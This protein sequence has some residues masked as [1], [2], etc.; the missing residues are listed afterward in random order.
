MERTSSTSRWV[1][2]G[3]NNFTIVQLAR[4][5]P[6]RSCLLHRTYARQAGT[7]QTRQAGTRQA[8]QGTGTSRWVPGCLVG[9][10]GFAGACAGLGLGLGRVACHP[11]QCCT[12]RN[13]RLIRWAYQYAYNTRIWI[14]AKPMRNQ[15][16]FCS[17]Q[18]SAVLLSFEGWLCTPRHGGPR[19]ANWHG[20]GHVYDIPSGYS[21]VSQ[22]FFFLSRLPERAEQRSAAPLEPLRPMPLRKGLPFKERKEAKSRVPSNVLATYWPMRRQYAYYTRIGICR[23]TYCATL[24]L[25]LPSYVPAGGSEH[26][27]LELVCRLRYQLK[28]G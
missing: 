1:L 12:I 19:E 15:Y 24:I 20:P 14:L 26:A 13:A 11:T 28:F 7:R 8:A 18:F 5:L 10:C 2:S 17:L 3:Y 21:A 9:C 25:P 6:A 22:R 23:V 4:C 27:S 16:V